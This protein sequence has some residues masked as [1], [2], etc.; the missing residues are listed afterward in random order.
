MARPN[1]AEALL[2]S[3]R[4]MRFDGLWIHYLQELGDRWGSVVLVDVGDGQAPN[5]RY[6]RGARGVLGGMKT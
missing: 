6:E 2:P 3:Q 4:R 5:P 1:N